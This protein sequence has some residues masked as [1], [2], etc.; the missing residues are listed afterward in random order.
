[1]PRYTVDLN[2]VGSASSQQGVQGADPCTLAVEPGL[3][4]SMTLQ[5]ISPKSNTYHL[6]LEPFSG[7]VPL[8]NQVVVTDN[9]GPCT[10]ERVMQISEVV[11]T[12]KNAPKGQLQLTFS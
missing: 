1:M 6:D 4:S 3:Y 11:V 12:R 10:G 8:E 9:S 7:D 2:E 5:E